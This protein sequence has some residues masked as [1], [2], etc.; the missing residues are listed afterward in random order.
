VHK[1]HIPFVGV[2]ALSCAGAGI[3]GVV[4]GAPT[5]RL[6]G[7]YLAIVTLGFGEIVRRIMENLNLTNG[8]AG[9]AD[10]PA[11]KLPGGF[12]FGERHV[13]SGRTVANFANYYYLE[14]FVLIGILFVVSRVNRSRIGRAWIAIRED[15][16]AAN[17]MGVNTVAIKLLAF[18]VGAFVAGGAGSIFT[19]LTSTASP[20]SFSF[21]ESVTVLAMVVLGGMGNLGGVMLGAVLLIVLPEK[22]RFFQDQR[23]LLF[24]AALILMMRFR[25]EGLIPSSRRRREFKEGEGSALGA[26]PGSAAMAPAAGAGS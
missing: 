5:L 24:G 21:I 13:L 3:A 26:V 1:L 10:V 16:L 25:P 12:N 17:A 6:R 20:E 15:E 19:H 9:V 14:L 11:L 22:L 18:G 23:L 7:D 4:L 2:F 8:I